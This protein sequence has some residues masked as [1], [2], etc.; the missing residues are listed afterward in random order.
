[1]LSESYKNRLKILSGVL[2]EE[3]EN[4]EY[5][6]RDIGGDVFYK[7]VLGEKKWRFTTELDFYKNANKKN[8]IKW[9][10]ETKKEESR[11]KKSEDVLEFYK[12]YFQN[13]SPS[14][15]KITI[16][17]DEIVIKNIKNDK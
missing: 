14:H 3:R 1:M 2:N 16:K 17:G 9:D 7:R 15:F 13:M 5:Q 11:E 8:T 12:K 10:N 6:I 4:F